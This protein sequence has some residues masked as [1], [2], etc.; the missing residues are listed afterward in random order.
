MAIVYKIA[1]YNANEK[2][3][4]NDNALNSRFDSLRYDDVNPSFALRDIIG[5]AKT[6]KGKIIPNVDLIPHQANTFL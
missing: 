6:Y 3:Y 2:N 4:L 1:I 5:P